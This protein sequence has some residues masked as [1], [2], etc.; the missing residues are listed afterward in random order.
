MLS[1]LTLNNFVLIDALDQAMRP[2]LC[3]ITGETGAGKSIMLSALGLVTGAR[4]QPGLIGQHGTRAEVTAV[5]DLPAGHPCLEVLEEQD[6]DA[7]GEL[8]LRRTVNQDGRTKAFV[9]GTA[10]P[11]AFLA[12]LGQHLVEI[13]GQFDQLAVLSPRNHRGLL[14]KALC[15]AL[16]ADN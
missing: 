7:E 6:M 14:D 16:R 8:I 5:F 15:R 12:T 3:V 10:V 2:G 4:V 13:Q 1:H 9:N 11:V